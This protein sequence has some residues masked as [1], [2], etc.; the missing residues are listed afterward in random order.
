MVG[1]ALSRTNTTGRTASPTLSGGT[2]TR[3][4]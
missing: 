4:T 3:E 1:A 2:W